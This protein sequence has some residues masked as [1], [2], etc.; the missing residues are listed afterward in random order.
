MLSGGKKVTDWQPDA[1]GRWKAPT[2]VEN[3]RQ[4]YVNGRRVVRAFGP[5][6]RGLEQVG[7]IGYSLNKLSHHDF[8]MVSVPSQGSRH[9]GL[10]AHRGRGVR[11]IGAPGRIRASA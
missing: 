9:C 3:F 6:P 1:D 8:H 7:C 10:E 11:F 4:L 2:D 5:V